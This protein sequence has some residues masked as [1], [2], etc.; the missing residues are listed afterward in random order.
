ML[1]LLGALSVDASP[2]GLLEKVITNKGAKNKKC[3]K[4]TECNIDGYYM[5]KKPPG[6]VTGSQPIRGE[7]FTFEAAGRTVTMLPSLGLRSFLTKHSDWLDKGLFEKS[8]RDAIFFYD[9]DEKKDTHY[10]F[11]GELLENT[12]WYLLD[13][14]THQGVPY[15]SMLYVSLFD[16]QQSKIM[17]GMPH[18]TGLWK[19]SYLFITLVCTSEGAPYPYNGKAMMTIAEQFAA[20]L[21]VDYVILA[22]LETPALFYYKRGYRFV[23]W[24]SGEQIE[25]SEL[26]PADLMP[27]QP[28]AEPSASDSRKRSNEPDNSRRMRQRNARFAALAAPCIEE[29]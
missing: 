12:D 15:A 29:L 4:K 16:T 6:A 28:P 24:Q 27:A 22:S 17:A 26:I 1:P 10:G 8:C 7:A 21:G 20:R 2:G 13:S 19:E 9:Y 25:V 18:K 5:F 14:G 23:S 11:A 3:A